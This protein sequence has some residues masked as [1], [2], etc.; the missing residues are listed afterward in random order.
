VHLQ[1]NDPE[2]E[3]LEPGEIPR[4][5]D[6]SAGRWL[7]K[8]KL[9]V[10]DNRR[11]EAN[12]VATGEGW[13]GD[14]AHI[15][16]SVKSHKDLHLGRGVVVDGSVVSGHDLYL[17]E[18]CRIKGPILAEKRLFIERGCVLGS[19]DNPTTVSVRRAEIAPGT[20][21]HGTFW[22]H[23]E[24]RLTEQAGKENRNG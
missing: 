11:I 23:E 9:E 13:I 12:L 4:V 14:G 20:V 21:A 3:P 1:S 17:A 10:P 19:P 7:I 18:G 16:G 22:A 15:A 8:G 2:G 5:I 6:D 24:G